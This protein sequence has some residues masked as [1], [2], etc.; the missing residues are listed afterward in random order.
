MASTSYLGQTSK[1][2]VDRAIVIDCSQKEV[3][4]K[5]VK[6]HGL[7]ARIAV[8]R[9]DELLS[10]I[11]MSGVRHIG[12]PTLPDWFVQDFKDCQRRRRAGEGLNVP[13]LNSR[14]I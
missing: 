9:T 13:S 3:V 1:E 4:L 5:F 2:L 10:L 14:G 12:D 6:P 11:E 7:E 8:I